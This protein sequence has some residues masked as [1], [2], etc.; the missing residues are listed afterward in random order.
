MWRRVSRKRLPPPTGQSHP[1]VPECAELLANGPGRGARRPLANGARLAGIAALL[2]EGVDLVNGDISVAEQK[3]AQY[4]LEHRLDLMNSRGQL[5]DAWR[6]LAVYANALL[7]IF[8]VE[9]RAVGVL[10]D[11]YRAAVEHRRQR[12]P[13][14]SWS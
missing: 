2:V 5:M 7:G 6:Q 9:Y 1:H 3:A 8:T 12:Q 10:A 11:Q 14:I 13:P 4:A